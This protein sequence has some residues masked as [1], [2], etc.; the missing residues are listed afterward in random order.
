MGIDQKAPLEAG[1]GLETNTAQAWRPWA[2]L[3][4]QT[5][6]LNDER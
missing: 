3:T 4:L 6:N 5:L 2:A 1:Y